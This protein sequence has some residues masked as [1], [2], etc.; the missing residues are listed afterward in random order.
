MEACKA[1][2]TFLADFCRRVNVNDVPAVEAGGC[3]SGKRKADYRIFVGKPS[4]EPHLKCLLKELLSASIAWTVPV[5]KCELVLSSR[6][7]EV[8]LDR[9]S[10]YRSLLDFIFGSTGGRRHGYTGGEN[11]LIFVPHLDTSFTSVRTE[12]LAAFVSRCY[13]ERCMGAVIYASKPFYTQGQL[14]SVSVVTCSGDCLREND[15][16]YAALRSKFYDEKDMNFDLRSYVMSEGHDVVG[17]DACLGKISID[18]QAFVIASQLVHA[19]QSHCEPAPGIVLV[20]APAC[21]SLVVQ[22][23]GL[24]CQLAEKLQVLHL[25]HEGSVAPADR[26]FD[27]YWQ[28]RKAFVTKA[29]HRPQAFCSPEDLTCAVNMLVATE[30]AYEFLS[31][32]QNV[33]MKL[34]ERLSHAEKGHYFCQ[35]TLA[36]I[37]AIVNKYESAVEEGV[38]PDLCSL[39]DVDC[40]LLSEESEWLLWHRL[41]QC[42][43]VLGEPMPVRLPGSTRVEV[44]AHSLLRALEG[45]CSEFS[46]YYSKVRVLLHPEPHLSATVCA[47]VWLIKAVHKTV[48]C[49]LKRF[50]L[51]ALDR[52]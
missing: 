20:V 15:I 37:A 4:L 32:K 51:C 42:W 33:K 34:A 2:A 14:D 13:T 18:S 26:S 6:Y 39:P 19:V 30:V 5:A 46:A 44:N 29:F 23:A 12:Q 24:L 47:R 36:R 3:T 22:Q 8:S 25:M 27:D 9:A 38:Y 1:I 17:C 52:M 35:Y 49:A 21:K 16:V 50:G 40:A 10:A 45:L 31:S 28:Q 11:V 48:L 43:Q 7:V 41:C